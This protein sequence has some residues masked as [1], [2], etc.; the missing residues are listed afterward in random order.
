M[1]TIIYLIQKEFIQ[2]FRNKTML[3]LIFA[4]PIVLLLIL[5]HA[6]TFEMKHINLLIIDK[7]MSQTSREL[8]SKFEG[9]PFYNVKYSSF[10]VKEAEDELTK[11]KCD[12]F[13]NIPYGFEKKLVKENI[14]DIQLQINA[15]N[16]MAAG[17]INA[18]S[19]SI[20]ADFNKKIITEWKNPPKGLKSKSINITN[21]YWYNPE[22]NYKIYMVPGILVIL[23][24]IIGMFLTALNIVREKEMGTIEQINVTPIKKT[25]FIIGKL[26]PFWIIAMFELAFGLLVG[27]LLFHIPIIGSLF[28]LFTFAGLYL[29][30]AL[31][32]G[33][34]LSTI[35][36]NQQ[37]VMFLAFFFMLVFILM[38]GLFTSVESMPKWAQT[39]NYINPYYYFIKV[40]RMILLKGSSFADILKEIYAMLVYATIIISLAIWRYRKTV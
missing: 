9:S 38:S 7:D 28:T 13:I 16:A 10:S 32:I 11:D 21:S 19:I 4:M 35:A 23:V 18:Y 12:I 2:V 39:V 20:I 8:V 14:S 36:N 6:A 1:R 33:L 37:Q 17:L 3:P 22:L 25:Y 5:V 29:I 30:V 31:G 26:L 40:I 24:T 15:I 27:K 34:F